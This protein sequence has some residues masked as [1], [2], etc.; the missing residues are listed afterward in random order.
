MDEG[1]A[2]ATLKGRDGSRVGPEMD[3]AGETTQVPV[4]I[5]HSD[6]IMHIVLN[7]PEV[8]NS[9]TLDMVRIITDT[10]E[11]ARNDDEVKLIIFSGEGERGF[12]AGGDIKLLAR[13]VMENTI[14]PA[15]Q[16]LKEENDLD[17]VIHRYPKPVVVFA[18]GI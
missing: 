6:A 17:L 3:A 8:I 1:W 16:F 4:L 13:A 15:M 2:Y 12:C 18:H 5:R 10:L 14:E 7:R 11:K 9:L